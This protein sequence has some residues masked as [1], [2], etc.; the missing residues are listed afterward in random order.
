MALTV[1]VRS[2][3]LKAPPA[4]SF[5]APRIVIGRGEGCEVRLPDPSVSHRHASIRQ[6]GTDYIVVDEGSTN[7]TF[8]GPV[9][10]SPQAPR[11]IRSGDFVRVGRVWLQVTIEH[12]VPT[13]NP[14]QATCEIALGL[15]AGALAEQ[16]EPAAARVRVAEGPDAGRE[17]LVG[18]FDEPHVIGRGPKVALSLDD[19]DASRR[20]CEVFRRGAQ[21]FVRELGSKNGS[22]L[23]ERAI[24]ADKALAWPAGEVLVIGADRLTYEDPVAEALDELER[25]ADERMRADESVDPPGAETPAETEAV[26]SPPE[27]L[28]AEA[29]RPAPIAERPR[30]ARSERRAGGW[31]ATDLL[32]AL[33]AL[34][35]LGLSVAG[36]WWLFRSH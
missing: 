24:P 31:N 32:V 6:R 27:S 16:G 2:G 13:Q 5:D 7:G 30:P 9:R 22:R 3:G 11:V 29:P 21:L 36:L 25:A 28:V 15:V 4:I 12:V 34:V 20:H 18:D 8:V 10:L 33:L 1:V 26:E 14:A 19:P 23:G 17:L 35:V